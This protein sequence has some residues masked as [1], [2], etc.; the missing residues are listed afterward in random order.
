MTSNKQ[1]QELLE[2]VARGDLD[3]EAAKT[4]LLDAMRARP[5]EDLGFARIDHHR[6]LRQGFPEVVLGLGK[7]PAQVAAISQEI[8]KRGAT[9]LV[10]RASAETY[11]AVRALIPGSI[12][13]E[14]AGLV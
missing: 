5:F 13:L 3:P 8:V 2:R 1:L 14:Q 12:Y 10:T 7:T 4:Q 11:E 6:A 9:L